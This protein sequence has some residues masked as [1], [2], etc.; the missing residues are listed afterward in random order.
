MTLQELIDQLQE[1]VDH[2]T[3]PQS[4]VC[5]YDGEDGMWLPVTGLGYGEGSVE[6]YTDF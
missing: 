3:D 5:A 1:L 4:I 6:I 2:G